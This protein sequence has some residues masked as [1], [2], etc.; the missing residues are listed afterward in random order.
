MDIGA[1]EKQVL[2]LDEDSRAELIKKLVL[3][4]DSPS[5][6]ELEKYWVA[7]AKSRANELDDGTV[8]AVSG[9]EVLRKARLATR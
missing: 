6:E 4:L 8:V 9:A 3:N 5:P 7:E 2:E 1:I